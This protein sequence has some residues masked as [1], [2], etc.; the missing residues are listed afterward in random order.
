MKRS[1]LLSI[2]GLTAFAAP[3]LAEDPTMKTEKKVETK[4]EMKTSA[5]T[6]EDKTAIESKTQKNADGTT[7]TEATKEK[8]HK[9]PG[10]KAHKSKMTEKTT[11]DASG[12]IVD[13]T[14]TKEL[15]QP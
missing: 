13:Q 2:L 5:G 4:Q 10:M 6:T 9:G 3:A 11:K 14:K 7:T 1:A 15:K 8:M 12:N